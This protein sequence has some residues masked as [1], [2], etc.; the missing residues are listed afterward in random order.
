MYTYVFSMKVNC[1]SS[2]DLES[3]AGGS[4][5]TGRAS[6]EGQV[7]N[8]FPNKE[9]DVLVFQVPGSASG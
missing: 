4:V 5:V 6:Q 3:C 7:K 9:R 8:E 1:V 2:N